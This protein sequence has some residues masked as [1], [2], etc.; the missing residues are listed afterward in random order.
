MRVT[1]ED[2]FSSMIQEGEFPASV[3]LP[4]RLAAL[5]SRGKI[6]FNFRPECQAE[7]S[8]LATSGTL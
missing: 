8:P 5:S 3:Y 4:K 1:S 7:S 2:L 6:E